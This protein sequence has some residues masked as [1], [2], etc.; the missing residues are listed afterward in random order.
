MNSPCGTL[1]VVMIDSLQSP[2]I[3]SEVSLLLSQT[4]LGFCNAYTYW[5]ASGCT[6]TMAETESLDTRENVIHV[7]KM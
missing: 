3:Y 4:K 1:V 2:S 6:P 7:L 5:I